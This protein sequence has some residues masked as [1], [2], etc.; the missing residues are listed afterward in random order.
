M[1]ESVALEL[2]EEDGVTVGESVAD[3]TPTVL[4]GLSV[5][6]ALRLGV[7]LEVGVR[8]GVVLAVA[9]GVALRVKVPVLLRVSVG[10]G[11]RVG[12]AVRVLVAVSVTV[13]P[14]QAASTGLADSRSGT[15]VAPKS[16]LKL[17]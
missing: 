10:V 14:P 16:V 7:A 9:L 2:A 11:V 12:V 5:A 13:P 8:L 1:A 3:G 4:V 6:V 17:V 15:T